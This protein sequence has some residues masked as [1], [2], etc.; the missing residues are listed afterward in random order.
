MILR[1]DWWINETAQHER[2]GMM[3]GASVVW[4]HEG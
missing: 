3:L 1:G 4:M 2:A